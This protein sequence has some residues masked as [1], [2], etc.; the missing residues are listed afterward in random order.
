MKKWNGVMIS[1]DFEADVQIYHKESIGGSLGEWSG[2]GVAKSIINFD[3]DICKTNI[4]D[5][6]ITKLS[7]DG[8][9]FTFQGSG[10]PI[11]NKS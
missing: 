1:N 2:H 9:S 8:K 11:F 5:I 7:F 4:G 6:I 10:K 3:N